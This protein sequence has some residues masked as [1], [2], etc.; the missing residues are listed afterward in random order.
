MSSKTHSRVTENNKTPHLTHPSYRA[1]I[2]GLRAIAVLAVVFYH[3]FPNWIKGGFIGVDI[4]FVISGFLIST[5]IFSSL[6]RESFTFI[7]FYSRRVRRI[8]PALLLVLMSCFIFGWFALY[9]D[10][11]MQL[12]KHMAGGAAFVSNYLFWNESGYFDNISETKPLLHLWSLG[13]EEQFYIIWPILL[14]FAWLKKFNSLIVLLTIGAISFYLNINIRHTDE[15]AMFYSP[16]TRFWELLIGSTLAYI[17][18]YK[19]QESSHTQSFRGGIISRIIHGYSLS[20]RRNT[21]RNLQSVLGAL[22]IVSGFWIIDKKLAFPGWWATLPVFGAALILAGGPQSWVNRIIL[23]NRILVW[24]GLIS[25]PLYLWHWPLLSFARIIES[26]TPSS[27][28][29][30][31]LILTAIG[32]SWLTYRYIEKPLRFVNNGGVVALIMFSLMI[33]VGSVGYYSFVQ[34]GFSS[35]PLIKELS[36]K[37]VDIQHWQPTTCV[38]DNYDRLKWPYYSNGFC[39]KT[40]LNKKV[41]YVIWGDSHAEHLFPGLKNTASV[42]FM[43]VGRSSCPIILNSQ[44]SK[45]RYFDD[46]CKIVNTKVLEYIT[47]VSDVSV[48][49]ISTLGAF[50]F[51]RQG[52]A[53]AHK[54]INFNEEYDYARNNNLPNRKDIFTRGLQ[55]SVDALLAAGKK[56]VLVKDVPEFP[57]SPKVSLYRPFKINEQ[58]SDLASADYK[59]RTR[60]YTDILNQIKSRSQDIYIFDAA[61]IFLHGNLYKSSDD[62]HIY[63]REDGHHLSK[64][65]SDKVASALIDFLN[66]LKSPNTLH[67]KN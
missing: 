66:D 16:Q 54:E 53:A 34:G 1:D 3:A 8:F 5:I 23:S 51:E 36:L 61:A 38:D 20:P 2:D 29:R 4:F 58:N 46:E 17:S 18:L 42:N 9:A 27:N 50:Y 6:E 24:F 7:E 63:F 26:E 47:E 22:L 21:L 37:T 44:S 30:I 48:V 52:F 39:N 15:T 25:F 32:L 41:D 60:T 64:A 11:Y 12:G 31:I 56:V 33:L 62:Q 49:I 57:V 43:L 65:G 13:I 67:N 59:E 28:I 10:E 40:Q 19:P 14:W 45:G 55:A 35:R